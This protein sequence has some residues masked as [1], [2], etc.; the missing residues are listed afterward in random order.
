MKDFARWL[1]GG[2]EPEFKNIRDYALSQGANWPISNDLKP[3]VDFV[4]ATAPAVQQPTLNAELGYAYERWRNNGGVWAFGTIALAAFGGVMALSLAFGIYNPSFFQGLAAVDQA[5]GMITFLFAIATTGIVMMIGIATY[6]VP[7]E[8]VAARFA[9][10]KDLL[11]ILIGVL[12][13]ILGFYF[14]TATDGR[15]AIANVTA[16]PAIAEAG[17]KLTLS[18]RMLGG[19]VPYQYTLAFSDA[20]LKTISER[21]ETAAISK[22]IDVPAAVKEPSVTITVAVTDA[23]GNQAHAATVVVVQPAASPGVPAA[24]G[25]PAPERAAPR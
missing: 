16:T 2:A 10:A 21:S 20:A 17:K 9:P 11:A 15:I 25:Q 4:T 22:E 24:P 18:A 1:R 14:G 23:K 5:R 3:L 12:G 8:E 7:K 6:W 19:T 13:T